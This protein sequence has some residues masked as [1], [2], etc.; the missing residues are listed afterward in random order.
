MKALDIHR[1]PRPRLL[2]SA[3]AFIATSL[4]VCPPVSLAQSEARTVPTGRHIHVLDQFLEDLTPSQRSVLRRRTSGALED[5]GTAG[6][7]WLYVGTSSQGTLLFLSRDNSRA[8]RFFKLWKNDQGTVRMDVGLLGRRTVDKFGGDIKK[9]IDDL[10]R[11]TGI[12]AGAV[13]D[14]LSHDDDNRVIDERED[15]GSHQELDEKEISNIEDSSYLPDFDAQLEGLD[16]DNLSGTIFDASETLT[17]RVFAGDDRLAEALDDIQ[18]GYSE[19]I[20][21]SQ[22]SLASLMETM[23]LGW[24]VMHQAGQGVL[25]QPI[26]SAISAGAPNYGG[27]RRSITNSFP[28]QR[29]PFEAPS[30][31]GSFT[32]PPR[33]NRQY[34]SPGQCPIPASSTRGPRPVSDYRGFPR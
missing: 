26:P 31:R 21:M 20:Q 22:E 24:S 3:V 14:A 30:V 23:N 5:L 6:A 28:V 33:P 32:A 29:R 34:R 12:D 25:P 18:R 13:E 16:L 2:V 27:S 8:P 17:R 10:G 19:D 11:E 7:G 9:L 4:L 1:S 15:K